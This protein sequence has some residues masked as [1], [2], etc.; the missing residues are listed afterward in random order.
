MLLKKLCTYGIFLSSSFMCTGMW[1]NMTP[2]KLA[3]YNRDTVASFCA[4]YACAEPL[5]RRADYDD[6][7]PFSQVYRVKVAGCIEF[8]NAALQQCG[9]WHFARKTGLAAKLAHKDLPPAELVH[10]IED[11]CSEYRCD[12][13]NPSLPVDGT[14]S[15]ELTLL[16]VVLEFAEGVGFFGQVY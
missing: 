1:F 3:E 13:R 9:F 4:K 2:E 12:E 14:K 6:K 15:A 5:I 10:I 11:A 16:E 7:V 8:L